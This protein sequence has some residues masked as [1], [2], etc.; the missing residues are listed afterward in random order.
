MLERP[1]ETK[2]QGSLDSLYR[3]F[4]CAFWTHNI[5]RFVTVKQGGESIAAYVVATFSAKRLSESLYRT[6]LPSRSNLH[7]WEMGT[8]FRH[9]NEID[10]IRLQRGSWGVPVPGDRALRLTLPP[11]V[12]RMS[13]RTRALP[14]TRAMFNLE[15]HKEILA[16]REL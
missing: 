16:T 3:I 7:S 15:Y 9:Y 2:R 1:T 5:A 4:N 14:T 10:T 6:E 11:V 8:E 12:A 13:L